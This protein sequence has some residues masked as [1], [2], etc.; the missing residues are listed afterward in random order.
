MTASGL[1]SQLGFARPG[2]VIS[3]HASNELASE[4]VRENLGELELMRTEVSVGEVFVS[5]VT[6]E[7]LEDADRSRDV[8][9]ARALISLH[10][11]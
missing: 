8:A 2:L 1:S 7:A 3:R 10:L 5:R 11:S 4:Y 9:G 6:A